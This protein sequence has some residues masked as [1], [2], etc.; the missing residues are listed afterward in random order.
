MPRPLGFALCLVF[1]VPTATADE[2]ELARDWG[3]KAGQLYQETVAG[4]HGEDL[5]NR[6][7]DDLARFAVTADRLGSWVDESSR[8]HD[9]GCIFRGMADEAELQMSLLEQPGRRG[10]A[11]HR[12]ATLFNDAENI[13]LA[14][15]YAEPETVPGAGA[16][17]MSCPA[18]PEAALQYLTEQP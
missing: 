7:E 9:L 4:L 11:L 13:G 2:A 6:F 5:S 16:A 15:T 14:A 1:A 12:L 17:D 18:N 10:E 8:S 3:A